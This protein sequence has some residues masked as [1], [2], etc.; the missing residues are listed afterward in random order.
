MTLQKIKQALRNGPY[1][2]PG[3]C[4]MYFVTADGTAAVLAEIGAAHKRAA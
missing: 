3:S 2:W 1:A 4:P